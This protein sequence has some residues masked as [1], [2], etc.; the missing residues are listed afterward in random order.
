M[1]VSTYIANSSTDLVLRDAIYCLGVV[2]NSLVILC[3]MFGPKI[4]VI[5][6]RPEKNNQE[7]V[8]E[9][10]SKFCSWRVAVNCSWRVTNVVLQQAYTLTFALQEKRVD[11][12]HCSL[13]SWENLANARFTE[14][15]EYFKVSRVLNDLQTL[16]LIRISVKSYK[17]TNKVHIWFK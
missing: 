2:L 8:M 16:S 4:Y 15:V 9:S 7:T 14:T 6:F 5:V 17:N 3:A 11:R 13:P 12:C 1:Q 10:R